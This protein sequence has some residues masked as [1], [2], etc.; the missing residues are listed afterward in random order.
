VFLLARASYVRS[1]PP[2]IAPSA[3]SDFRAVGRGGA[4]RRLRHRAAL[5]AALGRLWRGWVPEFRLRVR[6]SVAGDGGSGAWFRGFS[7]GFEVRGS[8]AGVRGS[9]PKPTKPIK[10]SVKREFL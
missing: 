2:P 3:L 8:A 4:S 1:Q 7:L 6:G 5:R 9:G 10:T